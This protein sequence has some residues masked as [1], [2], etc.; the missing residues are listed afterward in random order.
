MPIH[1]L[2][3]RRKTPDPENEPDFYAIN[4][5]YPLLS[6]DARSE[7]T[8]HDAIGRNDEI[9]SGT[10]MR[11]ASYHASSSQVQSG[12]S[13]PSV[14]SGRTEEP[15][16]G[17]GRLPVDIP[18]NLR[19]RSMEESKM[20][21]EL[22]A[23]EQRSLHPRV[24]LPRQLL[25][26]PMSVVSRYM[27]GRETAFTQTQS[28]SHRGGDLISNL[29]LLDGRIGTPSPIS[30]GLDRLATSMRME[31]LLAYHRTSITTDN[32]MRNHLSRSLLA[33]NMDTLRGH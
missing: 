18:R 33:D 32:V 23:S 31:D 28:H 22:N 26:L 9:G 19:L 17:S 2:D 20:N 3:P 27:L 15:I 25:P 21:T 6:N 8:P 29:Q 13:L 1:P 12:D 10:A 11:D 7:P 16:V 24:L 30:L 5:K 14:T 4:A